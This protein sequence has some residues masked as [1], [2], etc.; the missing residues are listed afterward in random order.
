MAHTVLGAATAGPR[1]PVTPGTGSGS[2]SVVTLVTG[3]RVLVTRD[4][5]VALPRADGTTPF[6][7]THRSGDDLYGYAEGATEALAAER[8]GDLIGVAPG[9]WGDRQHLGVRGA[10][11]TSAA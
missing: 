4:G 3:D 9:L 6:T 2:G 7:Q 5:A 10:S 11:A 8:Q 1:P